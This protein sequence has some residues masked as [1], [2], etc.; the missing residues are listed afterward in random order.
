MFQIPILDP[1]E[2][3]ASPIGMSRDMFEACPKYRSAR[4][5][6]M[7]GRFWEHEEG[8]EEIQRISKET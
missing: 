2:A 1:N 3:K 4:G 8:L 6:V 7:M 5:P